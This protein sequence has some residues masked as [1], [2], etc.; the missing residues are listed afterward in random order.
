[1][2]GKGEDPLLVSVSLGDVARAKGQ[3]KRE[4][5][6]NHADDGTLSA[7]ASYNML[8]CLHIPIIPRRAVGEKANGNTASVVG[9]K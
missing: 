4:D 6:D 5:G 3:E 8:C 2:V 1:M 9:N 7:V